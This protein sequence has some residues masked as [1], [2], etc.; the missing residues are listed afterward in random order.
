MTGRN[1]A[2]D[3]GAGAKTQASSARRA[4]S[5]GRWNSDS[6]EEDDDEFGIGSGG[7]IGAGKSSRGRSGMRG[8]EGES[9]QGRASKKRRKKEELFSKPQHALSVGG[10][11]AWLQLLEG[12]DEGR[13]PQSRDE[14]HFFYRV[15]FSSSFSVHSLS[16]Q[17]LF[18][19]FTHRSFIFTNYLVAI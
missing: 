3:G 9:G 15:L 5:G 19:L 10:L 8:V 16:I 12:F 13:R 2:E 11:S 7:S 17:C 1:R 18:C 4:E 14:V 6:D